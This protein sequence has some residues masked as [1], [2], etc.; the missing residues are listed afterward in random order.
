VLVPVLG[1]LLVLGLAGVGAVGYGY[2]RYSTSF[3]AQRGVAQSD[4]TEQTT[5]RDP[6]EGDK[7]KSNGSQTTQSVAPP[8]DGSETG[9]AADPSAADSSA[10][11]DASATKDSDGA[12]GSD[13]PTVLLKCAPACDQ[14]TG[15]VCDGKKLQLASGGLKLEPGKHVCMFQAKGYVVRQYEFEVRKGETLEES[16]ILTPRQ[17]TAK[18]APAEAEPEQCGTF[19]NRCKK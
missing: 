1:L 7:P 9:S 8:G 11:G 6:G 18:P 2:Y 14:M 10:T 15:V 12:S 5:D 3:A 19:I 13:A 4:E 16:V 17:P